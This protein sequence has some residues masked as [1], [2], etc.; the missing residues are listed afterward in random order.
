[1][2]AISQEDVCA[3][4]PVAR[5][6]GGPDLVSASVEREAGE[7]PTLTLTWHAGGPLPANIFVHVV[8]AQ[9]ALLSQADGA[10]LG[11]TVPGEVWQAGDCI[12]DLR[13]LDLGGG[14]RPLT[15]LVGLYDAQGRLPA[16][17]RGARVPNDAV[18]AA[19]IGD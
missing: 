16:Y 7:R 6:E 12:H 3:G 1:V 5:F 9:G 15:V 10:V 18:P 19:Q 8:D 17:S 4:T 11:G 13:S 2:G 14:A